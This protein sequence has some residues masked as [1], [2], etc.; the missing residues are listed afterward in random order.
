MGVSKG[1]GQNGKKNGQVRKK[2]RYSNEKG[3]NKQREERRKGG[4][5]LACVL[6]P[7][8]QRLGTGKEADV[9]QAKGEESRGDKITRDIFV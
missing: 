2:K 8:R 7:F 9:R 4:D 3:K 5:R 6:S 1:K